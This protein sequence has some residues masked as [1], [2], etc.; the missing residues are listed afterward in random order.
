VNRDSSDWTVAGHVLPQYGYHVRIPVE[1]GTIE[2]AIERR[3]GVIVEWTTSPSL[4]YVNARPVVFDPDLRQGFGMRDRGSD[5]RPERMNPAGK[6]MAF[7]AVTT[8]GGFRLMRAREALEVTP[9]P[10]SPAFTARLRWKELPWQL[11]EPKEAEALNESGQVIRR[12]ALA[13]EGAEI[14]LACEPGVFSYR[15]R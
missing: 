4:A 12:V 3:D 6:P 10:N 1:G 8:N 2:S 13:K 14:V 5:P 7:G 9:L 11:A 15:L